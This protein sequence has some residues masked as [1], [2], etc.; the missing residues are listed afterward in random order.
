[1]NRLKWIGVGLLSLVLVLLVSVTGLL[2]YGKT[3]ASDQVIV[4]YQ[5]L[6]SPKIPKSLNNVS[7]VYISDLQLGHFTTD[8]RAKRIFSTL[9]Q[10]H[11]DCLLLGGDM[12]VDETKKESLIGYLNQIEA[13]L[14]KFA[15]LGEQDK[16][17]LLE[18]Y[19]QTN[20]EV[21]NNRTI[22]LANHA[23]EGIQL[24]GLA[25]DTVLH[26]SKQKYQLIFTHQP[27]HLLSQSWCDFALA[28]HAHGTQ[29]DWPILGGYRQVKGAIK[30][31]RSKNANLSF[32][33]YIS[34][35]LGN[36]KVD[37]RVFSTPEIDYFTLR[38]S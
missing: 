9:K 13:P 12:L 35:G 10:L 20:V 31:N 37:I 28:G 24:T 22:E 18:V 25:D 3:V 15:V 16:Q 7:I 36:Q 4:H 8:K 29:I 6:T 17:S 34:A 27:D 32:P 23:Q 21:L 5:N 14:G 30:L 26:L 1:M 19:Q 11:P 33:V 38:A 2:Y